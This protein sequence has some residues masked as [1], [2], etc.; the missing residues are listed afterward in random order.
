MHLLLDKH[1]NSHKSSLLFGLLYL[2]RVDV[3]Q[4][5]RMVIVYPNFKYSL[6]FT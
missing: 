2:H 4:M 1:S 6:G 3:I 5:Y